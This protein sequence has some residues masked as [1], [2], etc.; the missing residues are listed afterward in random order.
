MIAVGD[1]DDGNFIVCVDGDDGV[2]SVSPVDAVC[3]GVDVA[4]IHDTDDDRHCFL[5]L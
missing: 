5:F 4:V 3:D 1:D 2:F